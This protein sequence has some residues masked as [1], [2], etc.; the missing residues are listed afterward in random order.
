MALC[1]LLEGGSCH[2]I[3]GYTDILYCFSAYC[4]N[5]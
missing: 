2:G 1:D 5:C 3:I 4:C